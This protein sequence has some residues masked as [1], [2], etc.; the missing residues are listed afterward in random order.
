MKKKLF[1]FLAF[2]PVIGVLC[3]C[4]QSNPGPTP[5]PYNR[6][7]KRHD[8]GTYSNPIFPTCADPSV[9]RD[10][11]SKTYYCYTT[12]ASY[13]WNGDGKETFSA[14]PILKSDDLV[15][16][17]YVGSAFSEKPD[18][19]TNK[20]GGYVGDRHIW[21]PHVI[22]HNGVYLYY[23]S[24]ASWGNT[25]NGI[26][27][28]TSNSPEGPFVDHGKVVDQLSSYNTEC[29]DPCVVEADGKLYM[30]FGSF[31]EIDLIELTDDGLAPKN[32]DSSGAVVKT[33]IASKAYEGSYLV[34][35]YGYWHLF[36]SAGTC[37]EGAASSYY[38][39]V[40][41]SK[42]I[43]GPYKDANGNLAVLEGTGSP[44]ITPKAVGSKA[45]GTGHNAVVEDDDGVFYLFYHAYELDDKGAAIGGRKLAIDHLMFDEKEFPKVENYCSTMGKSG[46][47]APYIAA[48]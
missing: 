12:E 29:I 44:V 1:K 40:Y 30:S 9:F 24:L 35:M 28:A 11:V 42:D 4:G 13:D 26:G 45:A 47:K 46:I 38:V 25:N 36:G 43:M 27:V 33:K 3:S 2:I 10:P 48:N 34:W 21:A 37:C 32:V 39:N 19:L 8:T 14:G 7:P 16:W 5:D 18:W 23:Y 6:N 22:C 15:N 17:E 41:R 31:N 20:D